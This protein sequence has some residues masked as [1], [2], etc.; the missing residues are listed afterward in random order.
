MSEGAVGFDA[1]LAVRRVALGFWLDF[2]PIV[3]L[4][5]GLLTLSRL[6]GAVVD[7]AGPAATVVAVLAGFGAALF[8]T[9]VSFGVVERLRGRPLD[10]GAFASRGLIA[11]PPGFSVALLLGALLVLAAIVA[12]LLPP[13]A[14]LGLYAA[15]GFGV[16]RVI[17]A[18]PAAL[19]ERLAPVDALRRALA[20][21]AGQVGGVVALVGLV[22]LAL[23]PAWLIVDALVKG[24]DGDTSVTLA[25]PGL[26]LRAV[27]ELLAW[28][29]V[30]VVP[31]V[32]YV[33][34]VEAEERPR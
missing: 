5:F 10:P 21:G 1:A 26:W 16:V 6:A 7:P 3:T 30:A 19:A 29:V 9:I 17:A 20:L 14:A 13:A 34:L 27:F 25:S 23:G 32:A 8:A 15:A 28:S 18:V 31:G 4:G 12:L 33:G 2:A 24:I 11:S 22:A